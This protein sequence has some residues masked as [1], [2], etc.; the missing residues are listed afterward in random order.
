MLKMRLLTVVFGLTALMPAFAGQVATDIATIKQDVLADL[1]STS[2]LS[3]CYAKH[4]YFFYA[5]VGAV[6]IA[7]LYLF[8]EGFRNEIKSVLGVESKKSCGCGCLVECGCRTGDGSACS[9]QPNKNNEICA[10]C[11]PRLVAMR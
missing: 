10:C 6:A 7:A 9:M 1:P 4:P 11:A 8:N 5:G 2:W 3:D